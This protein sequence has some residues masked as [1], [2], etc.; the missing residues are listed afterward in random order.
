MSQQ[1]GHPDPV[2]VYQLDYLTDAPGG[3]LAHS[4]LALTHA[5]DRNGT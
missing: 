1:A 5:S 2:A 4:Y 3:S